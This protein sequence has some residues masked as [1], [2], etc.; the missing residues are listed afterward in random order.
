MCSTVTQPTKHQVILLLFAV[1]L[2]LNWL[3]R[4]NVGLQFIAIMVPKLNISFYQMLKSVGL[5]ATLS[6]NEH[7]ELVDINVLCGNLTIQLLFP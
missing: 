7:N 3:G 1:I 6:R 2:W 4:N 5:Y